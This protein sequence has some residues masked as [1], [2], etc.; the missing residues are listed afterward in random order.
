MP[1]KK[2][3]LL[4]QLEELAIKLGIKVREEKI[5]SEESPSSGGLCRIK[6]DYVLILNFQA[7]VEEKIRVFSEAVKSFPLGDMYIRPAVREWLE[8]S[9]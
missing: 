2:E 1:S 4:E 5:S 8:T 6:G 3:I 7:S 9:E